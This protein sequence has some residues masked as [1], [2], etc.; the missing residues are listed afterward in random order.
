MSLIP[1]PTVMSVNPKPGDL[2]KVTY[3]PDQ[4]YYT[5]TMRGKLGV[6][7]EHVTTH[8]SPNIW[9]VLIEG[10]CWNMHVYDIEVVQ[11]I[12]KE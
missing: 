5:K 8:S 11:R 7:I 12:E 9:K 1:K 6:V 10:R 2:V 4:D 3:M